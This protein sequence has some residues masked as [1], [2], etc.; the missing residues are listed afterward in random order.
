MLPIPIFDDVNS[1]AVSSTSSARPGNWPGHEVQLSGFPT[2]GQGQPRPELSR[3]YSRRRLWPADQT[4]QPNEGGCRVCVLDTL[5]YEQ[6][7]S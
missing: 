6:N 3:R 1:N 4:R 7:G 2:V 5:T